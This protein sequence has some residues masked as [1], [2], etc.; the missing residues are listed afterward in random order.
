MA[1]GSQTEFRPQAAH[2]C[3]DPVFFANI[4][5]EKGLR[6][7]A[8]AATSPQ[9]TRAWPLL[10]EQVECRT[11]KNAPLVDSPDNLADSSHCRKR[12]NKVRQ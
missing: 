9:L 4:L 10:I 8:E 12:I 3:T 2:T 6:F 7:F 5:L 1:S 11:A